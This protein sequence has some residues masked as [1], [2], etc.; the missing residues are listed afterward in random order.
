MAVLALAASASAAP[1]PLAA[2]PPGWS[3]AAVN[4][5]GANGQGHTLV[6]DR[7]K[8]TA[9]A[10]LTLTLREL[11]GSIVTISVAP[12]ATVKVDGQPGT[13]SQVQAGDDATA[14]AIDGAPASQLEVTAP[15][16]APVITQ[17]R[18][19]SAGSSS[20]T[21]READGTLVTIP[22]ATDAIIRVNGQPGS[23]SQ[24]Q[25]GFSATLVTVGS[26]PA[27][28]VRSNG[29]LQPPPSAGAAPSSSTP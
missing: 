11:D 25:R 9:V 8:V 29:K 12:D 10:A 15:L 24:I 2:L 4:V 3:H 14:L 26:L 20:V 7:G 1:G 19:V 13:F 5:V 17:G 6:Y 27:K 22:V 23:L 28:A 16:T 21:L 18:V